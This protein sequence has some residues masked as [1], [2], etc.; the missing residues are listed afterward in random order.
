M[1]IILNDQFYFSMVESSLRIAGGTAGH[2]K[3]KQFIF[4]LIR[5]AVEESSRIPLPTPVC[6]RFTILSISDYAGK[7][8]TSFCFGDIL[9]G[10]VF[11]EYWE[12]LL[13]KS[14]MVAEKAR[15]SNAA[16]NQTKQK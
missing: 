4:Y 3:Y 6:T 7:T 5:N 11:L 16:C 9:T 1:R 2:S 13:E 15:I 10:D 8:F 12:K 14:V